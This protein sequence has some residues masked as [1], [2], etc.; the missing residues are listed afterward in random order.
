MEPI[1]TEP[2]IDSDEN[3]TAEGEK[4][5]GAPL[6][7]WFTVLKETTKLPGGFSFRLI[8]NTETRV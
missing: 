1:V 3:E 5:T 7:F 6:M 4:T 8:V 2:K